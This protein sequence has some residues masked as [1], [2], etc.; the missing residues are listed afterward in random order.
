MKFNTNSQHQALL[1]D[2]GVTDECNMGQV[3]RDAGSN[4]RYIR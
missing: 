4:Y 3:D 1:I 2:N